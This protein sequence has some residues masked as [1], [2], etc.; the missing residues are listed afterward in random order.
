M[1]TQTKSKYPCDLHCH[2][3]RSD[4][5]DT[6]KE[7]I[8][9]A[10]AAGMKVI[11]ITDHDVC[12]PEKLMLEGGQECS[13]VEYAEKAGLTL[14]P[15]YEFSCDKWVDDVH[16]CGYGMDWE[17]PAL[18]EEIEAAKRS[19]SDAYKE[20]CGILTGKGMPLY[21]ERDI[22]NYTGIDGK[23]SQRKADEVQRKHI[24]E[25]MAAKGYASSWSEAKLMVKDDP[26]LNVKRRK[27]EAKDAIELIH[28]CGGIAIL[29][30][31]YLIDEK[32]K[33]NGE[34][35]IS[36]EEYIERLIQAGLDGIEASYSYDKTSYKGTQPPEEIE[37][38]I[39]VRYTGRVK[40]ISGGSDYHAGHKKGSKKVRMI[41][42]R[43]LDMDECAKILNTLNGYSK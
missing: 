22:L 19:K 37:Q 24:F 16:I 31:P 6:P 15:G 23:S 32:V 17:N 34:E 21:W 42:E 28:R 10:V 41:G 7:L 13:C 3:V 1:S 38:E 18:A 27:I 33:V 25:A 4:G 2:T 12:P 14:V 30:H 26:E 29:A 35:E 11:A 5:N 8:D 36:R 40:F 43:G 9:N 20:L 39:R